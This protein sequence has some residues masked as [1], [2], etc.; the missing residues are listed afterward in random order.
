MQA[1]ISM[2]PQVCMVFSETCC[3]LYFTAAHWLCWCKPFLYHFDHA[4]A[5][6]TVLNSA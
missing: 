2:L 3:L 5:R 6:L 1:A 4:D